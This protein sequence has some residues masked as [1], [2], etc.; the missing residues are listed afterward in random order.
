MRRREI[1]YQDHDQYVTP[2][3]LT[4]EAYTRWW[5][6]L[7]ERQQQEVM[8]RDAVAVRMDFC[9]WREGRYRT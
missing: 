2:Q 5:Q 8:E 6:A 7:S 4:G 3:E 9:A 1:E